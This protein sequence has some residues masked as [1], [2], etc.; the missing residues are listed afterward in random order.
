MPKEDLMPKTVFV[1]PF[2][3]LRTEKELKRKKGKQALLRHFRQ[4]RS[5][6]HRLHSVNIATTIES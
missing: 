6:N 5:E 2:V 1:N 3:V 4:I